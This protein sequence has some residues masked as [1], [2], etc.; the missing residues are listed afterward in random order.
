MTQPTYKA[1]SFIEP[2]LT[3]HYG[4]VTFL[5]TEDKLHDVDYHIQVWDAIDSKI[6]DLEIKHGISEDGNYRCQGEGRRLQG[7]T[8]E[9]VSAATRELAEF[10]TTFPG[11]EPLPCNQE[12]AKPKGRTL[13]L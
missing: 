3:V 9:K 10:L 12:E 11:I 7:N 4:A 2:V 1:N 5:W 13:R 8:R 6:K